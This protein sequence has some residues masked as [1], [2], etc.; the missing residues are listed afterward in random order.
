MLIYN[1]LL[2][3]VTSSLFI[4]RNSRNIYVEIN[5]NLKYKN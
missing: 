2:F 5:I 3:T 1:T 4:I